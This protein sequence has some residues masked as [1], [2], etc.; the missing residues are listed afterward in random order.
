MVWGNLNIALQ[1]EYLAGLS[2]AIYQTH[3][4]MMPLR[5]QKLYELGCRLEQGPRKDSAL[6]SCD[7]SATVKN[8]KVFIDVIFS[9]SSIV[10]HISR[11]KYN[12]SW[13]H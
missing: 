6:G 11:E 4:F 9:T 13:F 12:Y 2:K 8:S 1:F 10:I 5:Q 3:L 7:K